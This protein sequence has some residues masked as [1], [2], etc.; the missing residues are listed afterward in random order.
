MIATELGWTILLHCD[1]LARLP[2]MSKPDDAPRVS[3]RRHGPM[4]PLPI[5]DPNAPF[6]AQASRAWGARIRRAIRQPSRLHGYLLRVLPQPLRE[7][8]RVRLARGYWPNLSAPQSFNEKIVWRKLYDR[9]PLLVRVQD[10]FTL[11]GYV[12]ERLGPGYLPTLHH[13]TCDP[14]RVLAEGLPRRFVVKP[15]H[16]CN[17]VLFVPDRDA[18]DPAFVTALARRWLGE[19]YGDDRAEWCYSR[20]TPTILVEEWLDAG[21]GGVP[22]DIKCYVFGGRLKAFLVYGGRLSPRPTVDFFDR[23]GRPLA[24][25]KSKPNSREQRCPQ[26]LAEI[27]RVAERLGQGLDFVRVDLYALPGRIVVGE[28]TVYPKSGTEVFYPASFDTE[29]GACW[30]LPA[31]A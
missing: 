5:N 28:L 1:S 27:V 12:E 4:K 6:T 31:G 26:P 21:D 25:K 22:A 14:T 15:N 18:L 17:R 7:K 20:M 9:N 8:V 2:P 13:W 24:V 30:Q 11:R 16:S 19:R 3:A 29:L 10:K 23:N